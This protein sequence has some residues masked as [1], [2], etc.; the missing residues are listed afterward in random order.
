MTTP[1]RDDGGSFS[2]VFA[3]ALRASGVSLSW[4]RR[5]LVDRGNPV[6]MA[7]LS[8]WRSGLRAPEG[9]ASLA[10]VEDIERLLDLPTGALLAQVTERVRLGALHDPHIPFTE[11]Q[12]T[13]A[14]N[15]T[16]HILEAPPLDIT[17]EISTH[18][19]GDVDADGYLRRRTARTL[20]QSVSPSTVEFV[21]YTLLSAEDPLIRPEMTVHGARM[22]RD[23]M[24][25]SERVYAYVLQLDQPLS[26]G[27]TTM[28][29]VTMEGHGD[30]TSQPETGAFVVRPIRDLV[31]WTRFHEDAIP[32]WLDELERTE[33]MDEMV[34][35][36]LRP[37][38]SV[39]QTRR[40]FGPGALGIRWGYDP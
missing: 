4:L 3:A 13:E 20:L 12:I 40:D 38:A 34:Y 8:Y 25:A 16:L 17:R 1:E 10:A 6:S 2:Q 33:D 19:V 37:Q 26:L 21:T 9:A 36:P 18:V 32:D 5:R 24:H 29:E 23:H 30:D 22:V 39:H 31:L 27:V 14:L 7:T 28:I 35:R 11:E 15:E